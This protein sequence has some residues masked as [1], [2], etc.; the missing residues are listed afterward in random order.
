MVNE[1]SGSVSIIDTQTDEV[2]ATIKVGERP[3]ALAV[4]TAGE[5][6]YVSHE[7][8]TL[9]ERDMYAKEESGGS[10][11]RPTCRVRSI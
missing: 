9:I 3:R 10:E 4:A 7:D 5:R 2:S 8:G 11:A 6:L 1:G